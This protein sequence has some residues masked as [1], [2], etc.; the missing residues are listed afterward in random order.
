MLNVEIHNTVNNLNINCKISNKQQYYS[1]RKNYI[2]I[3]LYY[4]PCNLS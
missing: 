1:Y 2:V 4:N 3:L